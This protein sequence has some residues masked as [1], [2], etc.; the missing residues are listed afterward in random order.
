MRS[1]GPRCTASRPSLPSMTTPA[2]T[3]SGSPN[4]RILRTYVIQRLLLLVPTLLGA[5][6]LVFVALRVAPGNIVDIL[7]SSG[8]YASRE[9]EDRARQRISAE[10]GLDKP[11]TVQYWNWVTGIIQL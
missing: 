9:D 3:T 8:G 10:L 6:M 2:S 7:V 11:I 5:S 1:G 4:E